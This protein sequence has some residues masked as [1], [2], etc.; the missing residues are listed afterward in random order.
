[1]SPFLPQD[2]KM[3]R[4]RNQVLYRYR[5][6]QTFDHPGNYVA[7]VRG[8]GPD[9]SRE[10]ESVDPAYLI[11]AGRRLV[12][13]WRSEGRV[14]VGAASGSDRAPEFPDDTNALA[15]AQY[16]LV[17]PGRVFCRVWPRTVR[18]ART[19]C[20]LVW[21]AA[22]P[23]AGVDDWPPRCPRCG[24]VAG[25]RQLQYVFVHPCGEVA[26]AAPP[27]HCARCG[28]AD[29]RLVDT[30]ARFLDFRWECLTCRTQSPLRGQAFCPNRGGC[31]WSD[32][33]M[34]PQVHTAAAA[35]VGH[36]VTVINPRSAALAAHVGR[37]EFI[38][39]TIGRWL[40][41]CS[42]TE[43]ERLLRAAITPAEVPP[44]V[45]RSI[46]L[47]ER[48]GEPMLVEQ[49]RLLRER[50]VP[51]DLASVRQRV[52]DALG[53]DPLGG[54]G[55]G[56]V[57]AQQLELYARVLDLP[58]VGLPAL[59]SAAA[60][61]GRATRYETYRPALSRAGFDAT[62][63]RLITEF[64]VVRLAVGFSRGGF[65]PND[66]DLVAYKDRAARGQ[67]TKTMIYQSRVDTE[68]L[69]FALDESRVGRWL[70]A[71]HLAAADELAGPGGVK[72]WF[73]A[74]LEGYE[75]ELPPRW[76][77]EA[78]PDPADASTGPR[79]LYE[80]L[81]SAS[82]QIMRA[83]AVDSGFAE[84]GLSEYLFPHD[85]AFAIYPN[86]GTEFTIGALRTVF[87][88]NLDEIVARAVET[89]GCM[90]DPNCLIAN[91][92]ADHGCLQLAET[93]CQ[94]WNWFL[95]RW[96]LFGSPDRA[97]T[98]YWDPVMAG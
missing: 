85:L 1:M 79:A 14:A 96:Q 60:S 18:C 24:G 29:H 89:D 80:L 57:L 58:R 37:P 67:A 39:A 16:E 8:Y 69:V 43:V 44:E 12:R 5:P 90:Y 51:P 68:A 21:S 42:P 35:Y 32:K 95:S 84:E 45:A 3:Q 13:R 93:A 71:N 73:A 87:E 91:R 28:G 65:G 97:V 36:G 55:R 62:A 59:E 10:P 54:D 23:I 81:H 25:N 88:Q 74:R 15:A 20:G 66:T 56:I 53:Y 31:T 30:Y 4:N 40:G 41:V 70:V 76:D 17:Q 34:S 50:F 63:M 11:E 78:T 6:G 33:L 94:V 26:A 83:L 77:P 7:Q 52:E 22:E 9:V 72:R 61:A 2:Q 48:T 92:G 64:P 86:G 38:V 75:P 47:M 82:H 98:G 49:A 46:E 27:D 19:S